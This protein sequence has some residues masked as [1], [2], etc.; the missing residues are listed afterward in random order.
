MQEAKQ[1]VATWEAEFGKQGPMLRKLA[2][3]YVA[4]DILQNSRK[5]GPE[6]V[7]PFYHPIIRAARHILK[8]GDEKVQRLLCIQHVSE[9]C[10]QSQLP[11]NLSI[12]VVL[13]LT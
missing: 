10:T 12:T 3:L 4:N 7:A 1:I 11:Q 8:H 6:F 9:C 5:K 13:L 2:L